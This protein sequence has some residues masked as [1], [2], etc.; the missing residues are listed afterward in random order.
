MEV[1]VVPNGQP[2]GRARLV[3]RPLERFRT[4]PL[5]SLDLCLL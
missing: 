1:D 3:P 5:D 4:P 2:P